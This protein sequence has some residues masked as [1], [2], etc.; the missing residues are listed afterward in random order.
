MSFRIIPLACLALIVVASLL[1]GEAVRREGGRAWAFA[2]AAGIQR[3]AGVAFALSIATVAGAG[4][5]TSTSPV[6]NR[7]AMI[8]AALSAIGG[9]LI[10]II[11]Q[12]QM[13]P[14]WRVGVRESDA[15]LFVR[16]GL[17]RYSRNPIF[18]G[19]MLTG[20][21]VAL[22][23]DLWWCWVALAIFAGACVVQV[24]IEEAHLAASFGDDY[25]AF[26]RAVPRWFGL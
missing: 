2:E 1:R 4:L 17:F 21:G 22:V 12:V 24:R 15:P 14:A 19:M 5:L 8:M 10:V 9:T 11:A 16:H 3:W 13:G 7:A 20:F 25:A 23:A 18:V 6:E 26:R